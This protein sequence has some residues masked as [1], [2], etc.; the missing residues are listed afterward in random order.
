MCPEG[1]R[2]ETRVHDI[3]LQDG[4]RS[5]VFDSGE[6][7]P[8][9]LLHGWSLDHRSLEAIGTA[10]SARYRVLNFDRRGFGNSPAPADLSREVNDI[11]SIARALDL[12]RLHL[13]GVSQGTRVALRYAA[14]WPGRV[15]SLILQGAALDGYAPEEKPGEAIP[16]ARFRELAQTGQIDTLREEWLRHPMMTEGVSDDETRALL[17]DC[18]RCYRGEDLCI[19]GPALPA[20]DLAPALAGVQAPALILSGALET[21]ARRAH[22]QRLAACLPEAREVVIDKAGHLATLTAAGVC[23]RHIL[24]FLDG[25]S[26]RRPS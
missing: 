11:A 22:A 4:Y 12:P 5:R 23:Q 15:A 18:V 10:L 3:P 26:A 1:A 13:L 9:L 6:G 2:P 17:R 14:R 21:A 16:I 19:G 7:E 8:V 24:D 20:V 25:V